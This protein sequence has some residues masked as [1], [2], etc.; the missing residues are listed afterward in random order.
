MVFDL[1]NGVYEVM[2]LVLE[3]G[4][5]NAQVWLDYT[6]C[7]GVREPPHDWFIKG[8]KYILH[9]LNKIIMLLFSLFGIKPVETRVCYDSHDNNNRD[10]ML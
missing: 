7:D 1:K 3:P 5:Y 10:M 6:L 4:S 8:T 2:F 9:L